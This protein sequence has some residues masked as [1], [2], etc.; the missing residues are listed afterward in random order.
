[1]LGACNCYGKKFRSL[2]I[3]QLEIRFARDSERQSHKNIQVYFGSVDVE[4]S[5]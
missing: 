5:A 3:H 1:M 4:V 2:A